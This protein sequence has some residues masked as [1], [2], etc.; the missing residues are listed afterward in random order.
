VITRSW[1][2]GL[3][4]AGL[5][6]LGL[7]AVA[8]DKKDE[9][10]P[11]AKGTVTGVVTAKGDAWIEVTADGQKSPRRYVP[12]WQGGS[13]IEGGGNPD[14]AAVAKLKDVQPGGRVKL[15]WVETDS[16]PRIVSVEVLKDETPEK[17]PDTDKKPEPEKKPDA[18]KNP[19]PDVAPQPRP[20][21]VP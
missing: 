17:K 7:T 11:A 18:D 9:K 16:R 6:A 19:L 2:A 12:K 13:E 1:F 15:E 8:Q 14:P 4:A 20:K 21:D 10:K 5:I 3:L